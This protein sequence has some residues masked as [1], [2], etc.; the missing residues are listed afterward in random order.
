[1]VSGG[2]GF[3]RIGI[4]YAHNES[5]ELE[6]TIDRV[7]NP[8]MVHWDNSSTEFDASDWSFAFVSNFLTKDEFEARYPKAKP[9]AFE[10]GDTRDAVSYWL[11]DDQIRVAEYWLR[12]EKKRTLLRFSN[13]LVMR[14]ERFTDERRALA[15]IEGNEVTGEREVTYY[16]VTRRV[17]S[18][19]EVLE[20]DPW[21]GEIISG[22]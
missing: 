8:L 7:P 10:G 22:S 5:F 3:F 13:G 18:G 16:D 1:M 21:P 9:V 11:D 6:C 12:E 4:D 15:E 14:E 19:V 17:I 20:E 2:F